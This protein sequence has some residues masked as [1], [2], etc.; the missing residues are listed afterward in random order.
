ME[1]RLAIPR[2]SVAG[3]TLVELLIIIAVLG[4]LAAIAVPQFN[5]WLVRSRIQAASGNLQQDLDWAEGYAIRSGYPVLVQ[6]RSGGATGCSWTLTPAAPNVSQTV[7]QMTA[8]SFASQYPNTSCAVLTGT[9]LS[10]VV[11][12]GPTG[13]VYT[14][15]GTITSAAVTFGTGGANASSYGYWL[16][17]LSGAGNLRNC[18]TSAPTSSVCNLQ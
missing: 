10:S 8:A 13:M 18:A 7:P 17:Q 16:V 5:I 6:I 11:N 12:V 9:T 3:F 4:I 1:A 15:S 14:P 2:P